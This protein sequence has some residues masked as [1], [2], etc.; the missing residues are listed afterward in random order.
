MKHP[1][2]EGFI[3][4]GGRSRRMGADKAFLEIGGETFLNQAVRKV[5]AVC[6]DRVKVVFNRDQTVLIDRLPIGLSVTFDLVPDRGALGGIHSA[7]KNCQTTFAFIL[8]VDLPLVP[9]EAINYL[10]ELMVSSNKYIAGVPRQADERLQ[11]LCAAYNAKY[12][13]RP[14]ERLM[15]NDPQ[16]SV[17]DFVE[18]ISPRVVKQE[19]FNSL[20]GRNIFFNVNNQAKYLELLDQEAD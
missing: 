11:P 8:A 2:F 7:L 15:E 17:R 13:L 12:C 1:N 4:A 10:A 6:E 9:I 5:S 18:L 14:L 20:V 3:L 16:A 19:K